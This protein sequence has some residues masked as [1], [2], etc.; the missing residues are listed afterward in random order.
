MKAIIIKE[1][2]IMVKEKANF[3]FLL[4]MPLIFIVMF[5]SIFNNTDDASLT[6]HVVDQDQS[7]ASKAFLKQITALPGM[8]VEKD[9][10]A[11]LQQQVHKI[12]QGQQDSLIVVPKDFEADLNAGQQAAIKLYQDPTQASS[13]APIE[14][15][16]NNITNQYREQKLQQTLVKMGQ[17]QAEATQALK[18]PIQIKDVNTTSDNVDYISQVV[19]GMTVMFV[20]YIM[21]SMVRRFFKEKES[22]LISRIRSTSI[23]PYYYLI[24]MW[25]PF[26]LTVI[27]QCIVLFAFGHWMYDLKLGDLTAMALIIICI[28]LCG[29]GI[30]L[31]LSFLVSGETVGMVVTQVIALAGAMLGGL[32][33]PSYLMPDFVQKLG[34]FFPQFWAQKALQDI[35]VHHAHVGDIWKSLGVLLIFAVLGFIVAIIRFPRFLRSAAN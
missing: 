16:L 15:V 5:G 34:H 12:E 23:K 28:S 30:G 4:L 31:A 22:G 20:F 18:A 11:N 1:L 17:T 32:W 27:A 29:T 25:I 6:F 7:T 33:V 10:E 14:S 13:V 2:K 3:F 24:G 35:I 21:I 19:P 26:V 8:K 9:S